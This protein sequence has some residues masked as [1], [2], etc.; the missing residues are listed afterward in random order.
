MAFNIASNL[1]EVC[2]SLIFFV[3][4]SCVIALLMVSLPEKIINWN[5]FCFD[6]MF[7]DRV[8]LNSKYNWKAIILHLTTGFLVH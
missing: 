5:F 1:F 3:P 4:I 7:R 8:L 6:G 2:R